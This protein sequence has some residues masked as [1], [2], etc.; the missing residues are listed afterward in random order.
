M[1][2]MKTEVSGEIKKAK[3]I[4]TPLYHKA[5]DAVAANYAKQYKMHEKD[6]KILAQKLKSEWKKIK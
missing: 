6:I 2:K 5:V 3:K 1:G 4:T